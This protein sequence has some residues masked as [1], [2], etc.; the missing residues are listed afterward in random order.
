[1]SKDNL[2]SN[3]RKKEILCGN[4]VF[5]ILKY[6][7]DIFGYKKMCNIVEE[8]GLEISYIQK[9]SNWVSYEYYCLLLKKLVEVTKDAKSPYKIFLKNK[10]S[11]IFGGYYLNYPLNYFSPKEFNLKFKFLLLIHK[12]ISKIGSFEVLS[13]E[14]DFLKI[15]IKLNQGYKYDKNFCLAFQ[16]YLA[17]IPLEFEKAA[18]KIKCQKNLDD[19]FVFSISW[20][21]IK[22]LFLY[23]IF[24]VVSFT[25]LNVLML[26]LVMLNIIN[27]FIFFNLNYLIIITGLVVYIIRKVY[28]FRQNDKLNLNI[29]N[30]IINIFDKIE[31]D[32]NRQ[33]N[34]ISE[35]SEH[36]K[37]L[38]IIIN[39]N[40]IS[41]SLYLN[42]ALFEAAKILIKELNFI[43]GLFFQYK[44]NENKLE[45]V[46]ELYNT[47]RPEFSEPD[48]KK[49]V[50]INF[51]ERNLKDVTAL[52][53]STTFYNLIKKFNIKFTDF[54]LTTTLF[55]NNPIFLL[56]INIP[57]QYFGFFLFFPE[58]IKN[59]DNEFIFSIFDN[60]NE[61]IKSYYKNI[62]NRKIIENIISNIP[63][64]VIIF[65]IENFNIKYA[66]NVFYSSFPGFLK[67][68]IKEEIIN[69]NLFSIIDINKED[70]AVLLNLTKNI[71]KTEQVERASIKFG[72]NIFEYYLFSISSDDPYEK[73]A[74]IIMND[75][76]ETKY[77]QNQLLL[78]EK[79]ISL[80][81]IA[82]GISHEINNPLYGILANAEEIVRDK[83]ADKTSID[84]SK[85][86]M[87][88]VMRISDIIKDLSAYSKTL[89]T[90]DYT[91][92]DLNNIINDS[93][94]MLKYS[95]SFI[96]IKVEK[97][98]DKLKK[99]N[100]R[101]GELQQVFINLF[102][103]AVQAMDGSGI[104]KISTKL[105]DN[106]IIIKI[107]DTGCGIKAEDQKHIFSLFYTTKS[108]EEGSGQGLHITKK[109]LDRYNCD[110]NFTSEE[111]KGTTFVL[112]FKL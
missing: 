17:S 14:I 99:I 51:T 50:E 19:F 108:H 96:D 30:L 36:N 59:I 22:Y 83:N 54:K 37:L 86:I 88:Y 66:N 13:S 48:L 68:F 33:S 21:K 64:Y 41:Y 81:K 109:I 27:F 70:K 53:Y 18:P 106:N 78:N 35:Q 69:S 100:A 62:S 1:M 44:Y 32:Y 67:N 65:N 52:G 111:N 24:S 110:I 92:V 57:D 46:F 20:K 10:K 107:S 97:K 98:F 72:S 6:L 5:H 7:E 63:S 103:N 79:L 26:Y 91:T 43:K 112:T 39:I 74:G 75:I 84:Y 45:C 9:K 77:F 87:D 3:Y 28:L 34:I 23:M 61:Q 93:L 73:L 95:S 8:L 49:F 101:K 94:N 2:K 31:D 89:R 4:F 105:N 15:K 25:L 58:D 42:T 71:N 56:P 12:K 55:P 85:E 82:S 102:N 104:L 80:G 76:T 90:E 60:V 47:A 38:S 40:K 29:N 11:S 16:G